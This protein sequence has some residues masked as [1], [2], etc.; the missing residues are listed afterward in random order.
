MI[1]ET[2]NH[3]GLGIEAGKIILL[4]AFTV[5]GF[6]FLITAMRHHGD[7]GPA[8][9]AGFTY[10]GIALLVLGAIWL[11]ELL[12]RTLIAWWRL[13]GALLRRLDEIIEQSNTANLQ[14]DTTVRLLTKIERRQ[15]RVLRAESETQ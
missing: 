14:L 11:L 5:G 10:G 13:P 8:W 7:V 9:A 3:E 6:A 12:V 4:T 1:P 15:G 2:E